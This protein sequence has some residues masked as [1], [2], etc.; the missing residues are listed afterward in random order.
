MPKFSERPRIQLAME[1]F[2]RQRRA[3]KEQ[4]YTPSGYFSA[5]EQAA[6]RRIK[7]TYS[8]GTLDME[9]IERW[10]MEGPARPGGFGLTLDDFSDRLFHQLGGGADV[11][12]IVRDLRDAGLL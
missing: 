10:L 7:E 1:Q 2:H 3:L 12:L 8:L 9:L 4:V 6:L 5:I 11:G